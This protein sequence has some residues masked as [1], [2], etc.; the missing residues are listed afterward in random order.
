MRKAL[1]FFIMLFVSLFAMA[2]FPMG[3]GQRGAGGGQP[4][5]GR[6]YGKIVDPSNKGVE[7]A[8]VTLVTTRM[9]SVTKKP[10]EVIVGGMLTNRNG[11]F[12][13]ENV[14]VM[15]RYK[16]KVTGIGFKGFEQNVGF[17]MPNRQG[18][19]NDPMAMLGALD[20]DLGNLKLTIDEQQ[21]SGVTITANRPQLTLGVDRKIFNVDR[22]LTSAGGSALDVMRQVPSVNVDVDGNV[23]VRNAAPQLFVDGRP[24]NLTLEQIPADAIESVEIIT[25][26]S[27]KYDASGGM[28]GILNVVLKKNKRVGYSGNLRANIDSRA[29]FGLGGDINIRQNKINVFAN[30]NYNQ[31]KSIAEGSQTRR[32]TIVDTTWRTSQDD[33]NVSVGYFAFLRGGFDYFINNR[34]TITVSGNYVRGQFEPTNSNLL[35]NSV[36]T[37]QGITQNFNERLA[38]VVGQF[39]NRG[40]Q[41]SYKHNFPKAGKELTSDFTY[42]SSRNQNSNLITSNFY[43]IAGGPKLFTTR[44]RQQIQGQSEN[45][46][47]QLDFVNPINDKT[48]FETGVRSNRRTNST[49]NQFFNITNNGESLVRQLSA[50]F[51]SVEYIHAAY[52]NFSKQV[53][54]SVS[55]WDCAPRVQRMTVRCLTVNSRFQST[56]RSA[57]SQVFS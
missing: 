1:A 23:T 13:I 15:G 56:S 28:A 39:R 52:V 38:D 47:F 5:A 16:L 6:L 32:T 43:D 22:N 17:E 14:P 37:P 46:V 8:S 9:D 45:M 30:A 27:A 31:R 53:K 54:N 12:S 11:E 29:R 44:Q 49:V 7:A 19:N 25:N 4:P 57:S 41:I 21:L 3:G 34:N 42:N 18:G 26:P 40:G 36:T 51:N 20:K 33:R 55:N 24:T 10:K 35:T 2:Q 48:K 50:N